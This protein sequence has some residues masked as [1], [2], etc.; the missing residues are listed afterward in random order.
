MMSPGWE[1]HQLPPVVLLCGANP[2]LLPVPPVATSFLPQKEVSQGPETLPPL[3]WAQ[4][5]VPKATASSTSTEGQ[6][7]APFPLPCQDTWH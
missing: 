7:T 5:Q 2:Y 6:L 3:Q 1:P 4:V